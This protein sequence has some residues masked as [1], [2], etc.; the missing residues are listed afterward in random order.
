MNDESKKLQRLSE[1]G[2]I[3][4]AAIWGSTFFVVKDL[5][6]FIN[7]ITLVGYRF[8]LAAL[9]AGLF[10]LVTKKSLIKNF[11]HGSLL[12]F[13][14]LSLYITQT[15]GLS[16]TTASN[17]GFIT[18]LFIIFVPLNTFIF[19]RK[20]PY[21]LDI[22]A[23][24]FSLIGLWILTG[25]LTD[26]NLGDLLTI[27]TAIAYAIHIILVDKYLREGD[28]AFVLGFQQFLVTGIISI[29]ISA[30]FGFQFTILNS[31]TLSTILFLAFLP[32]FSAF[33]IQNLAQKVVKP[34]GVSIILAFEPLF[35]A[36]FAWTLGNEPI[37]FHRLLGGIFI[38]LGLIISGISNRFNKNTF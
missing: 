11:S 30:T 2:L 38:V 35:A 17:S 29:L 26:F 5:L 19:F 36:I 22:I 24:C 34:L 12:G 10:C 6:E 33:I 4:S 28:S 3:Y 18:G 25:G 14:L 9:F 32:T 7:P 31:I 16:L 27:I 21:I 20:R 1:L 23:I 37:I 13:L 15:I 8:L